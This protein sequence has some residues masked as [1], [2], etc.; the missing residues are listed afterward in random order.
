ML[1][2]HATGMM[3]PE[4]ACGQHLSTLRE[5]MAHH[6]TELSSALLAMRSLR[7]TESDAFLATFATASAHLQSTLQLKSAFASVFPFSLCRLAV[8]DETAARSRAGDLMD[9][10]DSS[11]HASSHDRLTLACLAPL[12]TSWRASS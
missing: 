9:L 12:P 5:A 6:R 8:L 7:P 3:A 10:F 11:L 1:L 2:C 4:F